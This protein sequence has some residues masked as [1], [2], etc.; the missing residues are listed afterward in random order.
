[1][2]VK[3]ELLEQFLTDDRDELDVPGWSNKVSAEAW[4]V[5]YIAA[6]KGEIEALD[7]LFVATRCDLMTP[8]LIRRVLTRNDIPAA[9]EII[10]RIGEKK[11][12][13][14][15]H[16]CVFMLKAWIARETAALKK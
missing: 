4:A 6:Q 15:E 12:C 10:D 7:L 8:F 13:P 2:T 3:L 14:A 16:E 1:M 11:F 9:Q 5:L